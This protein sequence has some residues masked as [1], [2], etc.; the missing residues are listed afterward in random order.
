MYPLA[1][2]LIPLA[3]SGFRPTGYSEVFIE[4]DLSFFLNK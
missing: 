3:L 4:I 2:V 1:E